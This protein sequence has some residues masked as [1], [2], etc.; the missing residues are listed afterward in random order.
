MTVAEHMQR[1]EDVSK[2]NNADALEAAMLAALDDGDVLHTECGDL[3]RMF[4][5]LLE[6]IEGRGSV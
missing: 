2:A 6:K 5:A 3:V 1:L 4:A